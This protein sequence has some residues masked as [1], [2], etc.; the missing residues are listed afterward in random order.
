MSVAVDF[1]ETQVVDGNYGVRAVIRN[2]IFTA[3]DEV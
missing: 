2:V 1:C 3:G